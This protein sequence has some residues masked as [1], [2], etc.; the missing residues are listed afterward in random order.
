[1]STV[2]SPGAFSVPHVGDNHAGSSPAATAPRATQLPTAAEDSDPE[3]FD[4]LEFTP[5]TQYGW[6]GYRLM[7]KIENRKNEKHTAY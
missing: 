7:S 1:M 5:S 2:H 4:I 3:F 6:T